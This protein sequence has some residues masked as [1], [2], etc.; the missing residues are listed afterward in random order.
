MTGTLDD[1][2]SKKA[3]PTAEAEATRELPARRSHNL[4]AG[5]EDAVRVVPLLGRVQLAEGWPKW[6]RLSPL[7]I[8]I[9][10]T[11]YSVPP[12]ALTRP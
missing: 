12:G 1:V 10:L 11:G 7:D 6:S 4:V 2:T 5:R 8:G 3:E 9:A